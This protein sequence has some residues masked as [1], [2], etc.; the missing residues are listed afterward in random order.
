MNLRFRLVIGYDRNLAMQTDARISMAIASLA[1]LMLVSCGS[2][3]GGGGDEPP[4]ASESASGFLPSSASGFS[5]GEGLLALEK[6]YA[7]Y[8]NDVKR[9][10]GGNFS[11]D[12]TRSQFEGRSSTIIGGGIDNKEFS[13]ARYS[14]KEWSGAKKYAGKKY[15]DATENRWSESEWFL[16][17]QAQGIDSAPREVDKRFSTENYQAS[18]AREQSRSYQGGDSGVASG[19][20]EKVSEAPLIIGKDEYAAMTLEESRNILGR[21]KDE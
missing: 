5:E 9:D 16:Q 7:D 11:A 20:Q 6:K 18:G 1:G 3:T 8:S 21:N 4:T 10:K 15:E 19:F 17:K 12:S 2:L 14:K 13:A